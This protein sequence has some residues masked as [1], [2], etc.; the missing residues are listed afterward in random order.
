MKFTASTGILWESKCAFIKSAEQTRPR[1]AAISNTAAVAK[2]GQKWP[3]SCESTALILC[4]NPQDLSEGN[5]GPTIRTSKMEDTGIFRE[6]YS[7]AYTANKST[8]I[9]L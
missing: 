9:S 5:N 8:R 4:T 3:R 1:L 6:A 2:T 7:P